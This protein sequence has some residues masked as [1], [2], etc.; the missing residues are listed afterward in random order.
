MAT[1][2]LR[3]RRDGSTYTAV[4]YRLGGKQS[5]SSFDDHAEAVAFC[6]LATHAGPA[7]AV[8]VWQARHQLGTDGG[9]TVADWVR[10]YIDHKNI[11][12]GTLAKYRS[13]LR[14]D[15]E[16]SIGLL[17]L[18][19]VGRDDVARWIKGL[20]ARG[21][22]GKTIANK[23]GFLA[24][25][26]KRAV[27]A[28]KILTN[29]CEDQELPETLRR[30]MVCLTPQQFA[31]LHREVSPFWQPLVEFLV[32]SGCRWSE[33][34][35]LRPGDV[36]RVNSTV[37]ITRAWKQDDSGQRVLGT[38]KTVKGRRTIN[39]DAK[40]LDKLDYSHDW[41]FVNRTD[42]WVKSRGFHSRVWTPAV[43]RAG[44]N[45]ATPPQIRDLRHTCATWML[46]AGV[47]LPVV[48]EHLG[49][50]SIEV[51]VGVY[52]HINRDAHRI[53]AAAIAAALS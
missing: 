46:Q 6:N 14:N 11:S 41:L 35:A 43:E 25:T 19:A 39:V 26:M 37:R 22:G 21:N 17:P 28:G 42:A 4:L 13:Y 36:D 34:T 51:T 52:G 15:I 53:A 20:R 12:A 31:A 33:A 27:R 48:S 7:K 50:E 24:E 49:H 10:H 5:S 40:V 32:A 44:L 9:Q 2:R 18:G 8:E 38:T 3:Q 1:L 47:P 45:L 23:H 16:P 30:E 29:P